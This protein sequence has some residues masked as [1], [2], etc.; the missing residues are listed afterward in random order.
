M[1]DTF[2]C[3]DLSQQC[4]GRNRWFTARVANATRYQDGTV[5][6][7]VASKRQGREFPLI[8]QLTPAEARQLGAILAALG[9]E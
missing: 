7:E 5:R 4:Y 1:D 9:K 3:V 6:V 8:M 2:G